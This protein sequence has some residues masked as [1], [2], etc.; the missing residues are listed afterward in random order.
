MDK[1]EFKKAFDE[2]TIDVLDNYSI[3]SVEHKIKVKEQ[4]ERFNKLNE[5][6]RIYDDK[7][8]K[9]EIKKELDKL[10]DELSNRFEEYIPEH[11]DMVIKEL[12]NYEALNNILNQYD[13][14]SKKVEKKKNLWELIKQ[15]MGIKK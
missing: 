11:R 4:V 6:L 12:S 7:K 2:L 13:N 1:K 15:A 14:D 5:F 3:Y 9:D 10:R 8:Q